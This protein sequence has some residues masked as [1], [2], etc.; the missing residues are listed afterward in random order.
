MVGRLVGT[1]D[2]PWRAPTPMQ[3]SL[4]VLKALIV[5]ADRRDRRRA[6]DVA[7]GAPRRR[8]QLG[9]SLLL[10]ARRDLHAVRAAARRLPRRGA[11]MARMASARRRRAAAGPAGAV[12]LTGARV[13]SELTVPW[14]PGYADPRR[15]GIGNA[16]AVQCQ[17]DVYGELVDTLCLARR[18]GLAHD[19]DA[20]SFQCAL[21]EYLESHWSDR[22]A[23]SGRC[24]ASARR[25]RIRA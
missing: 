1:V 13:R 21:L 2:L 10:G 5:C 3:Q 20:W 12:R 4:M 18:A 22:T 24:A 8:A 14:L 16:A 6:D 9:L 19:A 23:A 17:L 25:S 15:C 7:A 11:C